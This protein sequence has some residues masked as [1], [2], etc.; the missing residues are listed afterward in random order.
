M[1]MLDL[2]VAGSET[3]SNSLEFVI[4]FMMTNPIVQEKVQKEIDHVVG[5][6]RRPRMA[7]K[8]M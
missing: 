7:D 3:T 2:F 5:R 4:L 8:S 1:T 6:S